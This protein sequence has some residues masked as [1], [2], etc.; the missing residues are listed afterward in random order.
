MFTLLDLPDS[1]EIPEAER[2]RMFR[3]AEK[4]ASLPQGDWMNA[5]NW[6]GINLKWARGMTPENGVMGCYVPFANT[7]YLQPEDV[8]LSGKG[9]QWPELM[10]PTLIHELRHKYQ[11]EGNKLLYILCCLPFLREY[12]LEKDAYRITQFAQEFCE[13]LDRA[14]SIA[15]YERRE[16]AK[17]G[18]TEVNG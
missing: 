4:Y 9:S 3:I 12:T 17:R 2:K 8:Y 11:Y 15:E 7:I 6:R 10:V 16:A 13:E 5:I 14:E 18:G 1:Y